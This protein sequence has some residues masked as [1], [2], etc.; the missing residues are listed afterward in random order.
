M[1]IQKVYKYKLLPNATQRLVFLRWVGCCRFVYNLCLEHRIVRWQSGGGAVSEFDQNKELTL[2]K[3]APGCEWLNEVHSQVLQDVV[4][5]VRHSFDHFFRGAGF[6]KWARREVYDS[7]CFPQAHHGSIRIEGSKIRLPKIGEVKFRCHRRCEGQIKQVTIKKESG[8][9]FVCI[10]TEQNYDPKPASENQ[11]VGIDLG[12]ARLAT[13]SNGEWYENPRIYEWFRDEVKRLQRKLSR[14][15][16]RSNSWQKTKNLLSRLHGRIKRVRRDYLHK[17]S[18]QI[19][20]RYAGIVVE[21]LRVGNMTRSAKGSMAEP[22]KQVRQKAGLNRSLLDV[23]PGMLLRMLEYKCRWNGRSFQRVDPRHTSRRCSAC[24]HTCTENRVSQ[25]VFQC[26]ECGHRENADLNASK[27]I[28]DLERV[29]GSQHRQAG[30]AL[31]VFA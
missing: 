8:G 19:V 10:L 28:R 15:E 29:S 7:F 14:Q 2:V 13:L 27:N 21:D 17:V 4:R 9:Y 6:P 24:G 16:F 23:S 20:Q 5:R 30:K 18:A 25:A 11:T 22:G 26:V 3:Q 12:I 1:Q 31:P